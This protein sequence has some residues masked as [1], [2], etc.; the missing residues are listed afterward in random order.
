MPCPTL[1]TARRST[2]AAHWMFTVSYDTILKCAGQDA[3]L[4]K[5]GLPVI[6]FS[7]SHMMLFAFDE[8][9]NSLLDDS[10]EQWRRLLLWSVLS[11][12]PFS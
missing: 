5:Y 8:V 10:F 7:K 9:P 1:A 11:N 2:T 4:F 12:R 3:A 6:P